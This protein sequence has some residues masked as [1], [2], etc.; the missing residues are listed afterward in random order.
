[1]TPLAVAVAV[2][3]DEANGAAADRLTVLRT[4]GLPATKTLGVGPDG[5]PAVIA[6]YGQAKRFAARHWG[7]EI[8]NDTPNDE[9]IKFTI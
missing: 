7:K 2:A 4:R 1:M 6:S 5:V 8:G 3:C 9:K